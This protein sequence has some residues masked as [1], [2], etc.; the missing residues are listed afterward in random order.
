MDRQIFSGKKKANSVFQLASS[1]H[2][3][4]GSQSLLYTAKKKQKNGHLCS[5][6]NTGPMSKINT[7]CLC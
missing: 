7:V 5:S 4:Q 6:G 3:H 1:E 2:Q